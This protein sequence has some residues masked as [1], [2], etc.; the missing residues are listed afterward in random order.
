VTCFCKGFRFRKK[1][2]SLKQPLREGARNPLCE[3]APDCQISRG[4][5]RRKVCF[6]QRQRLTVQTLPMEHFGFQHSETPVPFCLF[7]GVALEGFILF[8]EP[9]QNL[10]ALYFQTPLFLNFLCLLLL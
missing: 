8:L 6:Y 1:S 2:I 9:R 4:E 3:F 10:P 7:G 5:R